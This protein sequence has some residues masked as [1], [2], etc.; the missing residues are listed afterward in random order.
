MM[1]Y[2]PALAFLALI[3]VGLQAARVD[4][5]KADD[6]GAALKV[7]GTYMVVAGEKDGKKEPDERVKGTVV[8]FTDDMVIVTDKD[9]K[10][11]FTATY[12][13]TGTKSPYALTMTS[14]DDAAK[15][16]TARGLIEREGDQLRLIYA[17]PGGEAP[18]EF[19]TKDKQLMFV[20]K[21]AKP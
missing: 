4:E 16:E 19:K 7:A 20:L 17:L 6:K 11:T 18:T 1:R 9:K 15:G 21:P 3:L 12:K 13:I 2:A 5:K 8:R 14:K 10:E